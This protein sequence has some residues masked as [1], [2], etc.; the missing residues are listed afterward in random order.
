L[1]KYYLKDLGNGFGTFIKIQ[2]ETILKNNSLINIGDSYI[3]CQFGLTEETLMSESHIDTNNNKMGLSM[4]MDHINMLN[5]KIFSG[6]KK[7]DPLNFQP[8]KSVIKF[9]RS[10]EC[11]VIIEDCMLSRI[12]CSIEYKDNFGWIIRDGYQTKKGFNY[13]NKNSTNGTWYKFYYI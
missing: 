8:T 4:N 1:Q 13:E 9:G 11:E 5:I 12:H 7:Y 10:A 3:V 2:T 6:N